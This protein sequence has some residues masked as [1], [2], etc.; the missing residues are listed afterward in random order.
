MALLF[1]RIASCRYHQLVRFL[2]MPV[3]SLQKFSFPE[4]TKQVELLFT[5]YGHDLEHFLFSA[6]VKTI[7][8]KNQA[9]HSLS[10]IKT[11][12][13]PFSSETKNRV[14]FEEV[15]CAMWNSS[16][17]PERARKEEGRSSSLPNVN[18]RGRLRMRHCKFT[19][20]G[21]C[22]FLRENAWFS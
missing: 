9:P 15:F 11:K 18:Y 22:T 3:Y 16:S 14:R 12:K 21:D 8:I 2:Q 4:R 19:S 10:K 17:Y 20:V 13:R 1:A 7:V 6:A 5:R